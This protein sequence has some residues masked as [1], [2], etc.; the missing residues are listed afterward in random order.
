LSS[1]KHDCLDQA[2]AGS[3]LARQ[4]SQPQ[5][6]KIKRMGAL[7]TPAKQES[8]SFFGFTDATNHGKIDEMFK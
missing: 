8:S 4:R 7:P 3:S 1:A 5:A 6:I 2:R